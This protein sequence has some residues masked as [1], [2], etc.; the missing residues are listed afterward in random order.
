MTCSQ[1]LS[2]KTSQLPLHLEETQS[3]QKEMLLRGKRDYF[4]KLIISRMIH[5]KLCSCVVFVAEK[6]QKKKSRGEMKAAL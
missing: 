2:T 1:Y 5:F 6:Q 3:S 4:L